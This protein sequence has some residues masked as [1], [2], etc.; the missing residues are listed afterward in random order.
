M[1]ET[2]E[3]ILLPWTKGEKLPLKI[4]AGWQV[5]AQGDVNAPKP[6]QDLSAVVRRGLE[7]PIGAA[8]LRTS[9][10]PDTRIALVMDDAS[11]PTPV[12]RLALVILDGLMEAGARPENITGLFAVGTHRPMQPQE[13]EARAGSALASR[14][15]CTNCDCHDRTAFSYLGETQRGTPVHVS[16]IAAMADLRIL[17]GTIEP[18]PQ[19]GFG[20]GFKNLLPGLGS[21][22]SIG[23]NH[24]LMPS[25]DRYNMIGAHPDENPMR[26]DLEE[27][28]RMIGGPTFIV[29]VVLNPGLE[30]VAVVCGDPVVA[31]RAGAAISRE[32]YGVE[33]PLQVDVVVFSAYPMDQDLR[34][35]GKGILN[36]AGACRPGGVIV[37]FMRCEE[38]LGNVALPRHM[39]PLSLARTLVRAVGSRGVAF[40]A[41]HIP[42]AAPE[43]RFMIHFGLHVLKDYQV[44]IFSPQLRRA[45][46]SR[47]PPVL[48][49]DQER[50]LANVEQL[51]GTHAPDVAIFPHGGVTFPIIAL[52]QESHL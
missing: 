13:M 45:F 8:P 40:L 28:G 25:P 37:G 12:S 17:V 44:L 49:D 16:R 24:L 21:A 35:A 33:L 5:I 20:G 34:Q 36:V 15:A 32:I 19:A 6:I 3:P 7:E 4:P 14:I 2:L 39:P 50:L 48:Y 43:E 10:G 22:E 52:Q 11:R 23:Q 26:L 42:G 30:P 38:G 31:H 29:N 47:F 46:E 9:V 51:V 41:R 18:H 1:R 27:A